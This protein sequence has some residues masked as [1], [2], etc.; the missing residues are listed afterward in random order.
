MCYT[1]VQRNSGNNGT[2][3]GISGKSSV[4]YMLMLTVKQAAKRLKYSERNI[5]DWLSTGKLHGQKMGR[6]WRISDEA[7]RLFE[8][9]LEPGQPS[10]EATASQV[11]HPSPAETEE[12]IS[13][14]QKEHLAQIRNVLLEWQRELAQQ[15]ELGNAGLID[16]SPS[17][18]EAKLLFPAILEHCPSIR[19]THDELVKRRHMYDESSA[20]LEAEMR[21]LAPRE[22]TEYFSKIAV[23][24]AVSLAQGGPVPSYDDTSG[25]CLEVKLQRIVIAQGSAEAINQA[26]VQHLSLIY[27]YCQDQRVLEMVNVQKAI[28]EQQQT[29][30]SALEHSILRREHRTTGVKCEFCPR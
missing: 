28:L 15:I 8:K 19:G 12:S 21:Q 29:L 23:L 18:V 10:E 24:Y 14:A 25:D 9:S 7:I 5:R 20:E 2:S 11:V 22:A 13:E 27:R 30:A 16:I 17:D 26:K 1:P 4:T 6:Q 3:C